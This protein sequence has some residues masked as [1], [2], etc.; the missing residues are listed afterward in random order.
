[1][2]ELIKGNW[3]ALQGMATVY[4]QFREQEDI[5]VPEGSCDHVRENLLHTPDGKLFA[6]FICTDPKVFAERTNS[7]LEAILYAQQQL[8]QQPGY[9]KHLPPLHIAM[10]PHLAAPSQLEGLQDDILF[11]GAYTQPT[12]CI[13]ALNLGIHMYVLRFNEQNHQRSTPSQQ[14]PAPQKIVPGYQALTADDLQKHL[15]THLVGPGLDAQR[16]HPA[17]RQQRVIE[18]EKEILLFTQGSLFQGDIIQLAGLLKEG[19]TNL[20]TLQRYV[21]KIGAVHAEDYRQAARLRDEIR[22]SQRS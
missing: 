14:Q 3:N 7:D 9:P 10:L 5:F 1:M 2:A 15:F 4:S 6:S 16:L 12:R 18:L 17:Q 19:C 21:A 8:Q 11:T 13:E 20:D 22:A